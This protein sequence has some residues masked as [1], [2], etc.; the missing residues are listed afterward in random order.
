MVDPHFYFYL[1]Y[2][3]KQEHQ[4]QVLAP[5]TLGRSPRSTFPAVSR[6]PRAA[7]LRQ[8]RNLCRKPARQNPKPRQG[9]HIVLLTELEPFSSRDYKDAAPPGLASTTA[10]IQLLQSCFHFL[11]P[12][13]VAASRQRWAG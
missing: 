6:F 4:P 12:P 9:R 7:Q 11:V 10:P 8:E 13:S 3:G 1:R 2:K 5:G